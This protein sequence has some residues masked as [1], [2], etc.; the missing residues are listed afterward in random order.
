MVAQQIQARGIREHRVLSAMIKVPREKF[1][2]PVDHPH[3]L[4]DGPLSIGFGQTISQ[5]YIV[6]YMTELLELSG[7]ERVLE[8]GT[9]SGYQAAVLAELS[10]DVYSIER[11]PELARGARTRLTEDLGYTNIH[12]LE[13]DGRKGWPEEAP[14]D[15][16]IATAAP[17]DIPVSWL[18]QLADPGILVAPVGI[19]LQRIQRVKRWKGKDQRDLMIG[20]SFVPCI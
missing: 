7:V 5:P 17:E 8:I 15:R 3:A 1:V 9:G 13:G 19:G 14:F 6:A 20:V 10:Q 2:R 16:V 18:D 4:R 12:L 11:I